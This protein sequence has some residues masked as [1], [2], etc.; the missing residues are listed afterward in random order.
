ML[1]LPTVQVQPLIGELRSHKSQGMA[2]K[3]ESI[4][5]LTCKSLSKN[6]NLQT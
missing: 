6:V 1:S 2:I 3:K 4:E 5:K